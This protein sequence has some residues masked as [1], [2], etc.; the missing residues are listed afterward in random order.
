MK[1]L[2]AGNPFARKGTSVYNSSVDFE[3]VLRTLVSEFDRLQ[4]RCATIGGFALGILGAPRQTMDL[5]F[6]VHRDDL[7]KLHHTLIMLGYARVFHTENVS[8]YRHNDGIWGS[9]DFIHA[10]REISLS[11]L[12]RARSY[13]VFSGKQTVRS[14][15]PEDIIG[16]KVQAMANDTERRSQEVSDIERLMAL[17]G[18]KLDWGRIQEYYELFGLGEDAKRLKERFGSAE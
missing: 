14:V 10:F 16:L 8:Q 12:Q 3:L 18:S 4:I 9:I 5:D 2:L 7:Q 11:M 6:I 15:D 13:P 1:N 17:Y